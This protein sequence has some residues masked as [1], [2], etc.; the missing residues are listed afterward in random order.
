MTLSCHLVIADRRTSVSGLEEGIRRSGS[1][2][3]QAARRIPRP[4]S[5]LY[6][7]TPQGTR[8]SPQDSALQRCSSL[9]S[10]ARKGIW[11]DRD[12]GGR[13]KQR[14]AGETS[15]LLQPAQFAATSLFSK[16]RDSGTRSLELETCMC[17]KQCR[18]KLLHITTIH[19]STP[20]SRWLHLRCRNMAER[21][22]QPSPS[23]LRDSWR[24]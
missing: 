5:E 15:L 19:P 3:G 14:E 11:H 2:D 22:G 21:L 8:P 9:N 10:T 18:L 4:S 7:W 12:A 20:P 23:L 17:F 24:R 6:M 16:I 13:I 1:A